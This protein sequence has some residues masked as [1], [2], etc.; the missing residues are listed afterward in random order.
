MKGVF[1]RGQVT[2]KARIYDCKNIRWP[3][4]SVEC[5]WVCPFSIFTYLF[6][7]IFDVNTSTCKLAICAE[8]TNQLL[9]SRI[10]RHLSNLI[11]NDTNRW[12]SCIMKCVCDEKRKIRV[13]VSSENDRPILRTSYILHDCLHIYWSA[14]VTWK[15]TGNSFHKICISIMKFLFKYQLNT[16]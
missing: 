13:F 9:L 11:E 10:T 12:G 6:M 14:L 3:S 7:N 1:S 5:I 4:L 15:M 16:I 2:G 8:I